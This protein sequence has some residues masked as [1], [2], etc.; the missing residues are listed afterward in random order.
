MFAAFVLAATTAISPV[1]VHAPPPDFTIPSA[2]GTKRLYDLR[3]KVVVLNFWASWC[4]PCTDELKYFVRAE[5][6]YGSKIELMTISDEPHDIAATYLR[7][8][9][10]ELPILEDLDGSISKA[11]HTPPIPLTVVI[12]PLG[13]VSYISVGELSWNELQGAIDQAL[14]TPIP[15]PAVGTPAPGVLR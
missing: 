9:V 5:N 15:N 10:I 14:Q 12:D 4:P 1:H 8:R 11:Y 3:G 13:N 2:K 7:A 6:L